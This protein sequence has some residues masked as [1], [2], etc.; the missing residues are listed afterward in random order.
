VFKEFDAFVVGS[1][2]GGASAAWALAKK[3]YRVAVLERGQWPLRD[4][5]AWDSEKIL[6]RPQYASKVATK[7]EHYGEKPKDFFFNENVGGMSVF[8]G[9]A[10]FRFREKD[11]AKWPLRYG[12]F[13]KYYQQAEEC[14]TVHGANPGSDLFDARSPPRKHPYAWSPPEL[15]SPSKR[16]FESA[17]ALGLKPSAV[18]MAL[19]FQGEPRCIQCLT[20]DGYPCKIEAKSEACT[21]FLQKNPGGR[22]TVVTGLSV[23]HLDFSQDEAVA[24]QGHDQSGKP[25]RIELS[26]RPVILSAG[27]L[28]SPAILLRSNLSKIAEPGML[29]GVGRR[30]MRHCNAILAGIFLKPTNARKEF[31]KQIALFDFYDEHR[32]QHG[33]ATGVIQDIYTPAPAVVG[34]FSPRGLKTA[35]ALMGPRIQ[36]LL[37]IAEDE[38][39]AENRVRLDTAIDAWGTA[40]VSIRHHYSEKDLERRDF[41]LKQARRILK[42]SGARFFHVMRI[43]SFSHALGTLCFGESPRD[44]VLDPNC[45]FW[46]VKNLWALDGSFMPSSAGVNPSLTIVANS[47]RVVENEF[48]ENE[49]AEKEVSAREVPL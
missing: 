5:S 32:A 21:S 6:V 33:L 47:L 41:L 34:A 24:I 14:L 17:K 44:S 49:F 8:Y 46:G 10:A 19:R 30:L 16:I 31:Q 1:G 20:C 11:F 18:P 12:S 22:L 26:G 15:T 39:Q 37:C 25:L 43:D 7:V 36:N 4:A 29:D 38:A 40:K 45:K 13:E 23:S 48:V 9:G 35:A 2:L 27:A 3:G 42:K 28:W